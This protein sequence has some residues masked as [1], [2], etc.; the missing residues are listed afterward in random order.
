MGLII[1]FERDSCVPM[2]FF[3]GTT[4]CDQKNSQRIEEDRFA[5][6]G[7]CIT[8]LTAIPNGYYPPACWCLPMKAG[9]MISKNKIIGSGSITTANAN[10][11]FDLGATLTGQGDVY[12]AIG[13]LVADL[14]ATLTGSG[15][16]TNAELEGIVEAMA[17]LSGTGN[18]TGI[19]E[20]LAELSATL[21]G[22]GD[23]IADMDGIGEMAA[24]IK[25]YGDLS[26]EGLRDAVWTAVASKYVDPLTMG[27]K[28]NNAGAA[29]NPWDV[30]L[31]GGTAG[32]ILESLLK[33]TGNKVTKAGNIITIYETDG[34]TVWKEFDLSNGGRIEQ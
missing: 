30:I 14:L 23:V 21:I 19:I 3:G 26:V 34:V 29:A 12:Q 25:G 33:L 17:T 22:S 24:T 32:E 15:N 18:I 10:M 11:G 6:Y 8:T 7:T 1:N 31:E 20:A 4:L 13:E 2:K 5:Q 16:I 28:V 9:N 27:G